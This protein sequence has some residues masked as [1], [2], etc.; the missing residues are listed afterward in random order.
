M[1][2]NL[3]LGYLFPEPDIL[4]YIYNSIHPQELMEI[5]FGETDI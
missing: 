1:S 4:T 3:D 2:K 5:C